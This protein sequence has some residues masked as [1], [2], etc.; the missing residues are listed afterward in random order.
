VIYRNRDRAQRNSGLSYLNAIH[1]CPLFPL[2]I[3]GGWPLT[4]LIAN[5]HMDVDWVRVYSLPTE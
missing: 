4:G 1:A 3:G 2:K 5:S